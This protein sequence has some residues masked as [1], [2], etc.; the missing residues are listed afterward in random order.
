M[1]SIVPGKDLNYQNDRPVIVVKHQ[2]DANTCRELLPELIKTLGADAVRNELANHVTAVERGQFMCFVPGTRSPVVV[3][4]YMNIAS[5]E[6]VR[7]ANKTGLDVVIARVVAT[8]KR[9][10]VPAP[11]QYEVVVDPVK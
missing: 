10:L 8:A 4:N 6:A 9:K 2:L 11:E 7:L 3:H 5:D 1:I